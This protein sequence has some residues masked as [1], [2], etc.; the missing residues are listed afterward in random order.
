MWSSSK[1]NGMIDSYYTSARS[2]IHSEAGRLETDY[3]GDDPCPSEDSDDNQNTDTEETRTDL[4]SE[5]A[6]LVG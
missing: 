2:S 1:G 6:K 4:N 5:R 3:N